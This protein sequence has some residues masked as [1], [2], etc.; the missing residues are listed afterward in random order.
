MKKSFREKLVNKE[1]AVT[2]E[3]DI[4]KGLNLQKAYDSIYPLKDYIDA[5]NIPDNPMAKMRIS[6]ISLGYLIKN[7]LDIEPIFH[8]SCRDRNILAIQSELLGASALG[9]NNILAL[10]GD[11]PKAGDYPNAKGVFDLDSIELVKTIVNLNSGLDQKGDVIEGSAN[12]LI[13]GVA[14]PGS[15]DLEKEV[16]KLHKKIESGV[17][18]IQTQPIF[19]INKLEKFINATKNIDIPILYGFMPLKSA[20]FARYLN[21][22]VSG[23]DVP[24][25]FI[26][27]IEEK[28]RIA[29]LEIGREILNKLRKITNGVHI[30]PMGDIDLVRELF[31][32]GAAY[33]EQ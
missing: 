6:P 9:I 15:D 22:N 24:N 5:I 19:D 32:E 2:M 10:T 20:K 33:N 18:F 7:K 13:G 31:E 17:E 12:F 26:N 14:N 4:P 23:I 25:E 30:F 29:S 11:D 16:E 1:F 21:N 28:G 8:F 27:R 3:I